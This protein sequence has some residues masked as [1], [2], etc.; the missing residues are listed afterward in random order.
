MDIAFHD[1]LHGLCTGRGTKIASLDANMTHDLAAMREEVLYYIFLDMHRAYYGL[2][3]YRCLGILSGYG[4]GPRAIHL[5]W[6]YWE[7]QTVT[8]TF[9]YLPYLGCYE[10]LTTIT[11]ME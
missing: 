8:T 3:I 4:V 11:A 5:L 10:T 6:C 9:S 2:Y 1:V 7:L